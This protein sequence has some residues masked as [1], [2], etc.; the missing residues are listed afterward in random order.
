MPEDERGDRE[1]II[2][3]VGG[4]EIAMITFDI[5]AGRFNYR[6]AGV[7]VHA[8]HVLLHQA[9]ATDFWTLPAGAPA[10]GPHWG[11]PSSASRPPGSAEWIDAWSKL[12]EVAPSSWGQQ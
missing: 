5:G 3:A 10:D 8:G 2:T 1:R 4:A 12:N 6:D 11:L 9:E 7:C